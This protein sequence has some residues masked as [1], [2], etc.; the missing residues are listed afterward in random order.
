MHEKKSDL[1]E[2]PEHSFQVRR[3]RTIHVFI[4]QS[5][6]WPWFSSGM[7]RQRWNLF[8]WVK[9]MSFIAWWRNRVILEALWAT[10]VKR[11]Q[12]TRT[13]CPLAWP[14][15]SASLLIIISSQPSRLWR[16]GY[17][18]TE[19]RNYKRQKVTRARTFPRFSD[20]VVMFSSV[21]VTPKKAVMMAG[22]EWVHGGLRQYIISIPAGST[23][24]HGTG[25]V[26]R[27]HGRQGLFTC[28]YQARL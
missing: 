28:I 27:K 10:K 12:R 13:D 2:G 1:R 17:S 18:I 6:I 23:A 22:R 5:R 9:I 8:H 20:L 16:G 24:C 4:T 7:G 26:T 11:K 21:P 15:N 19:N 25:I 14:V 3:I